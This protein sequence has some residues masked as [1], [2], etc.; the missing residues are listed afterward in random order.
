[1]RYF[2]IVNPTSGRG[3][4]GRSIPQIRQRFEQEGK[5]FTL[6]ETT[7]RGDAID[8][9]Q[10][11]VAQGYDAV[12]CCSGD[13][14]INEAINGIFKASNNGYKKPVF[15]VIAIGTGN[16][17]AGGAGI[18]T[19]LEGSLDQLFG[20]G[21]KTID[22]GVIRGGYFPEGRYFG[23]GIGIGLDAA[24]GNQAEKIRW[25]R[26]ILAYLIG[27]IQTVFI[28]YNAPRL[29]INIDG[30]IIEQNS[31][32]V[33]VM[34]G[35]RMGGGFIMTPNGKMDDGTFDICIAETATKMR[36][37]GLIPHFLKGTQE[38]EKEIQ[39]THGNLIKIDAI[40]GDFP[41]HADGEWICLQGK[42]VEVEL[43][44]NGLTIFA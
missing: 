14:T 4:G 18:A 35:R 40:D 7:K 23:N 29:R 6:V 1:M 9:A 31:L 12:I 36:I 44:P 37:L 10:E 5:E 32:M 22:L 20:N 21:R 39:L 3:L 24:V 38:G 34:N 17:F 19:T 43:I 42:N 30:R 2:V 25:T 33:S 15:G 13:G 16:D 28:Y 26:G 8:L 27:L 41:C 11:A